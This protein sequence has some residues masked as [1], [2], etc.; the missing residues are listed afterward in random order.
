MTLIKSISGIRGTIGGQTGDTLNPL[1]IVKFT[2]A[3]AQF[4]SKTSPLLAKEGLHLSFVFP[5]LRE[6]K[7]QEV[8]CHLLLGFGIAGR[9]DILFICYRFERIAVNFFHLTSSLLHQPSDFFHQTFSK[10]FPHEGSL[11]SVL[12]SESSLSLRVRSSLRNEIR[13]AVEAE[14]VLRVIPKIGQT[15]PELRTVFALSLCFV[16]LSGE[17][18]EKESLLMVRRGRGR[19]SLAAQLQKSLVL[20]KKRTT[21]L[22][23]GAPLL[24]TIPSL[25]LNNFCPAGAF[26][27]ICGKINLWDLQ[28]LC[29]NLRKKEPLEKDRINFSR[30]SN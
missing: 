1:D 18:N 25:I 30:Y 17:R 14:R 11:E 21:G 22:T 2:T 5:P 3:Y 27:K 4:I 9:R 8:A 20:F 16:S 23:R 13:D 10:T 29:D 12:F 6:G 24:Q 19:L 28:D 15:C 7:K 26:H